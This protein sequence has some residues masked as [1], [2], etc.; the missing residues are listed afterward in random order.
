M[1]LILASRSPYRRALLE[2]LGLPFE[3]LSS[4]VDED[5]LKGAGLG[6]AN[7]ASELARQKA[8]AIA[9]GEAEA[10]VL[11]CDQV[12]ALGA[13]RFDQPGSVDRAI[14]QIRRL[15]G[16]THELHSAVCVAQQAR[17]AE[18]ELL[19]E[20]VVVARMTMRDLREEEIRRVV[21]SDQPL[22]CAG[23]YKL[24]SLGITLF[25]RIECEDHTAIE[26]LPL[27][28]LAASLRRLGARL[29]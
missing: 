10:V 13:E 2:R 9:E 12:C 7:L 20:F 19:D 17:D 23:A 21:E 11:G 5:G 18:P 1:R 6:P 27:L 22:D 29:P 3:Q 16:R 28:R 14:D 8:F 26:G 15:A 25:D 24:E 4:G